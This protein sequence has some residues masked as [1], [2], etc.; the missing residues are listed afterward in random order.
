[1]TRR[2]FPRLRR[3]RLAVLALLRAAGPLCLWQVA[4]RLGRMRGTFVA[5]EPIEVALRTL[6]VRG[7]VA[8]C[9]INI[10]TAD[11]PVTATG[12]RAA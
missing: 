5:S 3:L 8:R 7:R 12:W 4:H 11:G 2:T 6:A 9:A 10:D 1:M